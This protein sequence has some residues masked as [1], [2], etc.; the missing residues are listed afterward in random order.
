M[1]VCACGCGASLDG[2]TERARY[3]NAACRARAWKEATDYRHPTDSPQ[4]ARNAARNANTRK[5]RPS[6]IRHSHA[7]VR[8]RFGPAADELLT[9]AQRARLKEAA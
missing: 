4:T 6:D 3:A 9:D 2:R 7:K 5:A 8:A 1:R